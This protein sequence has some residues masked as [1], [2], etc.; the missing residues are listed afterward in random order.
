MYNCRTRLGNTAIEF[1]LGNIF[2][3]S[4]R[5]NIRTETDADNAVHAEILQSAQHG[6]IFLRIIG[7]KSR[8]K[9]DRYLLSLLQIFKESFRIVAVTSGLMFTG[10][11][12][13]AAADTLVAV[14]YNLISAI[15]FH[16]IVCGQNRAC[17]NT[18]ITPDTVIICI[19]QRVIC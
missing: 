13:G 10:I 8:G 16:R 6:C 14:N 9:K 19:Y 1:I 11:K 7:Q 3:I 5:C 2:D 18:F 4:P 15:L 17:G 12:A